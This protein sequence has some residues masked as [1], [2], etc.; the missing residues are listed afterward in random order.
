MKAVDWIDGKVRFI[1]QTL[2]P[3]EERFVDT[4]DIEVVAEAIRAL[5]IRGAPAIGVAAAFGVLL[6]LHSPGA[7]TGIPFARRF[8]L[9]AEKLG[10]TRPTAV[11]LFN[12]LNRMRATFVAASGSGEGD[13]MRMLEGEAC[14]IQAEDIEACHRI[15]IFGAALLEPGTSVLTHCNAGALATAGDGTALSVVTAAHRQGK[16]VRVYADETRP[17][18]Q[19]ARLT[20][21]ELMRSGIEVVLITDSTAASVLREGRVQAVIVGA[22]R[23]ARNGDTANKVGTYPLAVLA[24]RH[25]VPVYVA[26]PV[27]TLDPITATGREIPIEERDSSEVTHFAGVHIAPEGVKTYAPAFDVTPHELITAF[28]TDAGVLVPPFD[29]A[30][31]AVL[32]RS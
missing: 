21:W 9:A 3:H 17:L 15:G 8:D 22:D 12:T 13:A 32:G 20:S 24:R 2:L 26:A 29:A 18:L 23:I 28:V 7:S 10:S 31:T 1:D 4:D 16:I 27:S 25:N 6:G 5:R 11:N 19:G 30:L 14:R